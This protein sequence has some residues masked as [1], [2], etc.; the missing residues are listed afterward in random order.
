MK[1]II[2]LIIVLIATG[3]FSFLLIK[4]NDEIHITNFEECSK[5]YPVMESY[6]P[7]CITPDGKRFIEDIGNEFVLIDSISVSSPRPNQSV[8]SVIAIQGE[9][10]GFWFFEGQMSAEMQNAKGL[11]I[12]EGVVTADSDWMTEEFVP[13]S[14]ILNYS[15][16]ISGEMGKLIIKSAN[17]SGLEENSKELVIPVVFK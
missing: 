13:F 4:K 9:A 15:G 7:A 2:F 1:K 17:P 12:G 8:D 5:K 11:K 6:P 16:G 10:K 3:L 14:G